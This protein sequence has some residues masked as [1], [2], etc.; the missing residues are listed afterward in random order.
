MD[1]IASRSGADTR[2]TEEATT[3]ALDTT[4]STAHDAP[5]PD[6]KE[7]IEEDSFYDVGPQ[8]QAEA[9]ALF[10]AELHLFDNVADPAT[11]AE[12]ELFEKRLNSDW[13]GIEAP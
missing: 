3:H 6:V 4:T 2:P 1:P 10:T 13:M 11:I 5:M 12:A 8:L 9:R 7:E